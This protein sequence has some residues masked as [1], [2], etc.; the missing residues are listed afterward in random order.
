MLTKAPKKMEKQGTKWKDPCPRRQMNHPRGQTRRETSS[1]RTQLLNE[2]ID[3]RRPLERIR[4]L[5][6]EISYN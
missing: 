6:V 5:S 1:S 4:I 2:Y 3:R